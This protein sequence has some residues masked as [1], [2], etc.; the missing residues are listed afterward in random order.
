ML[1]CELKHANNK[2]FANSK[3]PFMVPILMIFLLIEFQD[4]HNLAHIKPET[5]QVEK[6]GMFL[7]KHGHVH[8]CPAFSIETTNQL[9]APVLRRHIRVRPSSAVFLEAPMSGP[10]NGGPVRHC[11]G[12]Q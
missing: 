9:H 5:V 12:A 4:Q 8:Y 2:Q 3:L 7:P 10:H 1:I 6:L 11:H